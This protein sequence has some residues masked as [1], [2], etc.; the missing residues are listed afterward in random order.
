MEKVKKKKSLTTFD[1]VTFILLICFALL[2]L[3]P[4]WYV[5]VGSLNNG[6]DYLRG[7]VNLWPRLFSLDNYIYV[8]NDS[9][10]WIGFRVSTIRTIIGT[11]TGLLFTATVSYAMSRKD[12]PCRNIIFWFML[13]TMFFGAGMI[14]YYL[15][16]K[17]LN[18][19]DTF[20]VYII[21]SLFNVFHMII[22][23][24]YFKDVPSE[25]HEAAEIDGAKE[26]QIYLKVYLPLAKPV[27]ATVCLWLAVGHWNSYFDS[28]VYTNSSD[29]QTLQLFLVKL[30]KEANL[31]ASDANVA[32]PSNITQSTVVATVRYAAIV[33]SSAPIL[34]VYPFVQKYMG[35]GIMLGSLKG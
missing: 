22:I 25:M 4:F 18:L 6:K 2:C 20:A 33:I 1:I 11:I 34:F 35:K 13:F 24:N 30:I 28:M 32:L 31:A 16:L 19:I 14:P 23:M 21:P 26:L 27:L 12:L 10:L 17:L 7:G 9:R 15:V 29:L 8:F 3:Y 5:I